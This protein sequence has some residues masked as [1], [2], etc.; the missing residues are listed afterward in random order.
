V[1]AK[2]QL[3]IS[4]LREV[5]ERAVAQARENST[6]DGRGYEHG[7]ATRLRKWRGRLRRAKKVQAWL[8]KLDTA[9]IRLSEFERGALVAVGMIVRL[10]D[11]PLIAAEVLREM[12]LLNADCSALD[13]YD[14]QN[15]R[16]VRGELQGAVKLRGLGR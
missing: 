15:L 13:D 4:E 7:D 12:G 11:Q 3:P 5:I 1:S 10:H 16:Q 14:K 9:E 6:P 2:N 8:E